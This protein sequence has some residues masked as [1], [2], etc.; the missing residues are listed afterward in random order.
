MTLGIGLEE[1]IPNDVLVGKSLFAFFHEVVCGGGRLE[2]VTCNGVS[3]A[4]CTRVGRTLRKEVLDCAT[5]KGS[6]ILF[7]D[8]VVGIF[9]V[10]DWRGDVWMDASEVKHSRVTRGERRFEEDGGM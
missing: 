3:G 10:A 4:F 7:G 5:F 1:C 8:I 9:P 2:D 6:W